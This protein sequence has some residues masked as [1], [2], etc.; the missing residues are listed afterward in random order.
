MCVLL[1]RCLIP[2]CESP[3]NA[4]FNAN[5]LP[6]AIPKKCY[7]NNH[8]QTNVTDGMCT[9]K[10]FNQSD[11]IKCDAFVVENSMDSLAS[12]VSEGPGE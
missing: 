10:W 5:W 6:D 1:C 3:T 9:A 2:E 7:R 12:K 8:I 11:V 4:T